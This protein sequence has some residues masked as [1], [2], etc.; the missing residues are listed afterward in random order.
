MYIFRVLYKY[1][2]KIIRMVNKIPKSTSDP[3]HL[4]MFWILKK[5]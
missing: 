2:A 3:N 5:I 4:Y 1:V